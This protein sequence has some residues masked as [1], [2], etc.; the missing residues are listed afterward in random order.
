MIDVD[1]GVGVGAGGVGSGS[2]DGASD[3]AGAV[4]DG[5]ARVVGVAR[6]GAPRA[7]EGDPKRTR[8]AMPITAPMAAPSA[9]PRS[10]ESPLMSAAPAPLALPTQPG[11]ASRDR[12]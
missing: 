2:A 7:G 8:T 1:V 10:C 4:A 3:E 6:E 12:P 5:L 9:T 11:P